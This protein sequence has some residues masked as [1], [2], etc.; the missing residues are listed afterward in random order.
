MKNSLKELFKHLQQ[1]SGFSDDSIPTLGIFLIQ[2]IISW[3][4]K[5]GKIY[6]TAHGFWRPIHEVNSK[7]SIPKQLALFHLFNYSACGPIDITEENFLELEGKTIQIEAVIPLE[8]KEG[9]LYPKIVW[10]LY[11]NSFLIHPSE[12]GIP[13]QTPNS[14]NDE[15]DNEEGDNSVIILPIATEETLIDKYHPDFIEHYYNEIKA[16]REDKVVLQQ[17]EILRQND[18]QELAQ[19]YQADEI[20]EAEKFE[21]NQQT[22]PDEIIHESDDDDFD[23]DVDITKKS[24]AKNKKA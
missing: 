2:K 17:L 3:K 21:L 18:E 19:S 24:K 7:N 5:T 16:G 8:S 6:Y 23:S 11:N 14:I 22:A 9:K 1:L 13:A 20:T 4:S 10:N 15:L 12:I